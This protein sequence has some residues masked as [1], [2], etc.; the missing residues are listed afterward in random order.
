MAAHTPSLL[1][2]YIGT[3]IQYS[4]GSIANTSAGFL[5]AVECRSQSFCFCEYFATDA[6]ALGPPFEVPLVPHLPLLTAIV[7]APAAADVL[8]Q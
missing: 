6:T 3:N 5:P 4:N 8:S 1:P 7:R 2:P